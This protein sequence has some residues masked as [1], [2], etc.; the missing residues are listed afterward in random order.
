MGTFILNYGGK[1]L[2]NPPDQAL[3]GND[4]N[5]IRGAEFNVDLRH[6]GG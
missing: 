1:I 2:N 4:P 5:S 6:A 3:Y